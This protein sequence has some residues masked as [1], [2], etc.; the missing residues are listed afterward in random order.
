MKTSA[1]LFHPGSFTISADGAYFS[2]NS[3]GGVTFGPEGGG[4]V[5]SGTSSGLSEKLLLYDLGRRFA[6]SRMQA[7]IAELPDFP[8][9]AVLL[10]RLDAILGRRY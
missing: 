7:E 8:Q 6:V 2:V 5:E 1:G 4:G 3:D 9:R 10:K